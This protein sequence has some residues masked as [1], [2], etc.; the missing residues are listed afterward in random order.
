MLL[1]MKNI[2]ELEKVII[3]LPPYMIRNIR[4]W[5]GDITVTKGRP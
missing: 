2:Y 3:V 4:V 5:T 1:L